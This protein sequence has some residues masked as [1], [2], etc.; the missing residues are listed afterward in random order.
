MIFGVSYQTLIMYIFIFIVGILFLAVLASPLKKFVKI[1]I[2]CGLGALALIAFNF[3]GHYF[4]FSIGMNPGSIL[5][6]G[7]LGIPGFI[8]LVFLKIYLP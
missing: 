4:N 1:L 2:N 6:V 7:L 3:V 8:L 5:T